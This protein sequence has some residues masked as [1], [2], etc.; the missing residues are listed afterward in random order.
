MKDSGKVAR[1]KR[2]EEDNV[3]SGKGMRQGSSA[4]PMATGAKRIPFLVQAVGSCKAGYVAPKGH[5][6]DET[7]TLDTLSCQTATIVI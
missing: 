1:G 3:T 2:K 6:L 4:Q 5:S 7:S